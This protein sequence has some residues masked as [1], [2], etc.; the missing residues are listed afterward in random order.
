[1]EFDV[2]YQGRYAV[3]KFVGGV[4]IFG[5]GFT[6]RGVRTNPPWLRAWIIEHCFAHRGQLETL[7][8]LASNSEL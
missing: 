7:R 8:V 4:R 1:M 3:G 5:R 6:K 2:R